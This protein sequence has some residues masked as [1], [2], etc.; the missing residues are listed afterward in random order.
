MFTG[1]YGPFAETVTIAAAL[2]AVFSLFL[3]K[4]VGRV[5]QWTWLVHDSPS[6]MVTAG[7]RA[8][9]VALIALSF[10]FID[11]TNYGGFAGGAVLFAIIMFVLIGWF[12]KFRKAHLCKVP[13]LNADGSPAKAFG[14]GES[15]SLNCS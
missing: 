9:A 11:K 14:V 15:R 10:I 6:F 13:L 12:D 2:L 3:L 8:L 7:A 4:M 1:K 5:S